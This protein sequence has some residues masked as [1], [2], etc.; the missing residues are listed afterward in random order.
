MSTS[1]FIKVLLNAVVC[2]INPL[3]I[4]VWFW[5]SIVGTTS[6]LAENSNMSLAE[7]NNILQKESGMLGL[8][9]FSDLR[10]I[11]AAAEY[12]FDDALMEM[13]TNKER[14]LTF[15]DNYVLF[16]FSFHAKPD[17]IETL[18]FEL[19]TQGF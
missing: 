7:I 4:F 12:Y 14:L 9:G 11:E 13:L 10:E 5:Q 3:T 18:L 1:D 16:E 2:P 8:T 19:L 6:H 17:Q 15:G